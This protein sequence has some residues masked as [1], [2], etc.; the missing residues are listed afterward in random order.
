MF[1]NILRLWGSKDGSPEISESKRSSSVRAP[2]I[3]HVAMLISEFTRA[4]VQTVNP[5][6]IYHFLNKAGSAPG[7]SLPHI[8]TV[9]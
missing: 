9:L 2:G 3:E 5:E 6:V 7:I 1:Q 4:G 8:E